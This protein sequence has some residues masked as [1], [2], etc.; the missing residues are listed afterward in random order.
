MTNNTQVNTLEHLEWLIERRSDV[1]HTLFVLYKF[2]SIRNNDVFDHADDL[3][4]SAFSLWR[5]VFLAEVERDW[6]SVNKHQRDFLAKVIADNAISYA[7]DKSTRAWSVA[8]YLD[9]AKFRLDGPSQD[10]FG[11]SPHLTYQHTMLGDVAAT[12][13]E[14]DRVHDYLR[15]LINKICGTTLTLRE[16]IKGKG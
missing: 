15:M 13:E 2:V 6:D 9:N 4:A 8:Y 5:A 10:L 3:I 7:D 11:E 16:P 12:R 14:W 1:Q